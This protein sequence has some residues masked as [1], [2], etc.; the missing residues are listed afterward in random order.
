MVDD[1]AGMAAN[2]PPTLTRFLPSILS[3]VFPKPLNFIRF[4]SDV[5]EPDWKFVVEDLKSTLTAIEPVPAR[6]EDAALLSMD[7]ALARSSQI[8]ELILARRYFGSSSSSSPHESSSY[9]GSS[10]GGALAR[11]SPPKQSPQPART[12]KKSRP[13]AARSLTTN[14]SSE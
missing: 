6:L 7:N 5:P 1:D 9:E 8:R 13:S 11:V 3:S 12:S 10:S 2:D 4:P 14:E